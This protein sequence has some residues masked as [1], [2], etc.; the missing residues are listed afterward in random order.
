MIW[1]MLQQEVKN[2]RTHH[3]R[4]TFVGHSCNADRSFYVKVSTVSM[5]S[6]LGS[7]E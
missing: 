4:E 2:G 7:W 1:T 6:S 3:D 5:V